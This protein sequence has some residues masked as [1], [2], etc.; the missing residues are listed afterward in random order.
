[1]VLCSGD[2]ECMHNIGTLPPFT[3]YLGP[4]GIDCR[5]SFRQTLPCIILANCEWFFVA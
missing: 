1:M 3:I 2:M 5:N 4:P